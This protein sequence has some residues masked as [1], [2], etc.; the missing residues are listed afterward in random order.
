MK[1]LPLPLSAS[2]ECPPTALVAATIGLLPPRA[3]APPRLGVG[4]PSHRDRPPP[5]SSPLAPRT[6]E[7]LSWY[8][9]TASV[10]PSP[11][12]PEGS[13]PPAGVCCVGRG[14]EAE[15]RWCCGRGVVWCRCHGDGEGGDGNGDEGSDED[16]KCG[17][18]GMIPAL[19]VLR[20]IMLVRYG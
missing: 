19:V 6:P 8:R 10:P 15:P 7:P 14:R 13:L 11:P 17:S 5:L 16:G 3:R 2:L 18:T 1:S 9:G 4:T 12:G 20:G